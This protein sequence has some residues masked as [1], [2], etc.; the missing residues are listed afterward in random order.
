MAATRSSGQFVAHPDYL[1]HASEV[2][3]RAPHPAPPG[4][5]PSDQIHVSAAMPAD[6]PPSRIATLKR[7]ALRLDML[8]AHQR[9]EPLFSQVVAIVEAHPGEGDFDLVEALNDRARCRF[10]GGQLGL[11]VEDYRRILQLLDPRDDGTLVAITMDQIHRCVEGARLRAATACLREPIALMIRC[12]RTGRAV[13]E[14]PGQSRLRTLARRLLARGRIDLGARLMQ[15]WLDEASLRGMSLD[16]ETLADL[17]S[18]ALA[19]LELHRPYAACE[20]FRSIVYVQL[21]QRSDD[22]LSI[23]GALRD[24]A[25]C[26]CA[27]GQHRSARETLALAESIVGKV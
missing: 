20:F 2:T 25:G 1:T 23:S 6:S 26:L 12:A 4:C 18:H 24:W 19:L 14:T 11:A 10:N 15:R 8:G 5:G 22:A 16:A 13:D 3:S 9:A 27:T 21:R 7:Q 17:R